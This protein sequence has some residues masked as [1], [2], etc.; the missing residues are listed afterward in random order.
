MPNKH[1]MRVSEVAKASVSVD[2]LA[3]RFHPDQALI[4]KEQ[5]RPQGDSPEERK[6]LVS[7]PICMKLAHSHE[8][9]ERASMTVATELHTGD[10]PDR[11]LRAAG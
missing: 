11:A 8:E 2:R 5:K 6:I 3:C 1:F 10:E 4:V 9:R 7:C